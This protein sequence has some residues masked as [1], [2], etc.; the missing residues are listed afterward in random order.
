MMGRSNMNE[1]S[2]QILILTFPRKF[3]DPLQ[4][5]R[6]M[7]YR[8]WVFLGL[9]IWVFFTG[10]LPRLYAIDIDDTWLGGKTPPYYLDQANET[11][12]LRQD[13]NTPGTAFAIIANNVTFDLGGHTITYDNQPPIQVP[14]GNFEDGAGTTASDWDFSSAP[15]AV[16]NAGTFVK[17]V[18]VHEGSYA[19]KFVMPAGN[20]TIRTTRAVRLE[21]NT[22]YTLSGMFYNC[23][24][25][26]NPGVNDVI[27][28]VRLAGTAYEA[29]QTG[30]T[31]RG[32]Q[33]RRIKFKTGS[34]PEEHII[35][36]GVRNANAPKG[37]VYVDNIRIQ[38]T[39]VHGITAGVNS[40]ESAN[41]PDL[42][43]YARITGTKL[44]NGSITQGSGKAD[45]A[46]G[47]VIGAQNDNVEIMSL[48]IHVSGAN[49]INIY[50]SEGCDGL[51]IHDNTLYSDVTVI[52]NRDALEGMLIAVGH[53]TVDTDVYRNTLVG[54][55]QGGIRVNPK[56]PGTVRVYEN[57]ISLRSRYS[58]G[59]AIY[60]RDMEIYSNQIIC[61]EGDYSCRGIGG[62]SGAKIY[63]NVVRARELPRNQEYNGC[64]LSGAYGIQLEAAANLEV[65]NNQISGV[66]D[67]C[68]ASAFR[69]NPADESGGGGNMDIHDNV[70]TAVKKGA[71]PAYAMKLD[72]IMNPRL[73][74]RFDHNTL[75]TNSR[76]IEA[77]NI[78]N[79]ELHSKHSLWS[80][81]ILQLSTFQV[82]RFYTFL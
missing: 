49:S 68:P 10:P 17:P 19:L 43:Q 11:Y 20:Q 27:L 57:T 39:H 61:D 56:K 33:Y 38:K 24:Y 23:D 21:S 7:S 36:V 22:T 80:C 16:R 8:F 2:N 77:G 55:P 54:G 70:F 48:T 82:S 51:K 9:A 78:L 62:G 40:W 30:V 4:I 67:L 1:N 59:F 15:N 34:V 46:H 41:Y 73:T 74:L 37:S 29:T 5:F 60:G 18:S 50:T 32:F 75:I 35:E 12:V 71:N 58:N 25:Q 31:W 42:T 79:L 81:E 47:V 72:T 26:D 76:W 3:L 44:K 69:T 28:F 6:A 65:F 66:A 14:N 13:V 53:A 63:N 45:F 64:C 52:G